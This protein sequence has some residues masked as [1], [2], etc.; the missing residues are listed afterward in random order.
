[1]AFKN[2]YLEDLTNLEKMP[3]PN[4]F[5]L[6]GDSSYIQKECIAIIKK[7]ML[8]PESQIFNCEELNARTLDPEAC[9]CPQELS[10]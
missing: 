7:R 1:M 2:L 10:Y 6:S 5:I 9:K 8:L 4:T 3:L